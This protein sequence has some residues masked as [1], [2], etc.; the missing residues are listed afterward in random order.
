M[1]GTGGEVEPMRDQFARER[2]GELP[3]LVEE[4]EG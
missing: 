2:A 3:G 1:G 4:L